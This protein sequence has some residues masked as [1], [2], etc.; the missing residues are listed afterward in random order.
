MHHHQIGSKL[1]RDL[2]RL[3]G[4]EPIDEHDQYMARVLGL[5]HAANLVFGRAMRE[6]G[7]SLAALS[8]LGGPTFVKQL[9]VTRE[10]VGENKDLYYEIQRLNPNTKQMLDVLRRSLEEFEQAVAAREAFR[11]YMAEAEAFFQDGAM[12]R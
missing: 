1:S 2:L 6:Q 9:A 5:P 8:H 3:V 10:V 11:H 4:G 7:M 12:T